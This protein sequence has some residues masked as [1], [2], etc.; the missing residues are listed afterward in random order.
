MTAAPDLR[1]RV[2]RGVWDDE[3]GGCVHCDD[4]GREPLPAAEPEERER[5]PLVHA[6]GTE[7][8][9]DGI[10]RA[11]MWAPV[12]LPRRTLIARNAAECLSRGVAIDRVLAY[13]RGEARI[14]EAHARRCVEGYVHELRGFAH[15]SRPRRE[16]ISRREIEA[17]QRSIAC[18]AH[19][20]RIAAALP[21]WA[22]AA[23]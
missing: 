15:R 12:D 5:A 3:R 13:L 4:T 22:A 19:A 21:S 18:E 8:G 6:Y 9:A 20:E 2:C 16:P 1:C 17:E 14:D 23:E 11:L 7:A 10:V